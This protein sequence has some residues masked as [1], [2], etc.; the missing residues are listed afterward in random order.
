[1]K[2][3][4]EK[5][6]LQL[7]ELEELRQDAYENARL[8]KER[9]KAYHDK[10]LFRKEFHVGQKV[11]LYNSRF[12]LFPSKLMSQSY[13]PYTITRVFPHGALEVHNPKEN[14]TF[15]VNGHRAKPYLEMDF[16]PRD[17]DMALQ[18]VQYA[19]LSRALESQSEE[20][21]RISPE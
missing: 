21:K 15:K 9:T 2:Q 10:Q 12:R 13:G 8:Y 19:A 3:E 17:E 20:L 7:V 11:L 5:Q 4:G 18:S 16:E 14:Q 1:M 6:K